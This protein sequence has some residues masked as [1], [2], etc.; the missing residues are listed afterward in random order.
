MHL[1]SVGPTDCRTR[2]ALGVDLMGL[3][4]GGELNWKT[5]LRLYL[6]TAR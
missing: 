2:R 6:I 3:K 4:T 1:S 5:V